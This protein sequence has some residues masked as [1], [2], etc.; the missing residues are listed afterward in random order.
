VRRLTALAILALAA[1]APSFAR[2]ASDPL[3]TGNYA[4]VKPRPAP[5]LRFGIDPGLAG[6]AGNVQLPSEPVNAAR[7][8]S[9]LKA[10]RPARRQLVLRLN[11]M[12]FSDGEAGIRRFQRETRSYAKDGFEVEL[13]VRYHPTPAQAGDLTAWRRYVR[14][15]VDAFGPNP[16]VVAMTITNEVNVSFSPNTS[17]GAFA[18]AQDALIE[19]IEAA[20]AEALR[21]GFGRLRFGFTYAYRFDP[22]HDVAF[23]ERLATR[24]GRSFR[25][26]LGFVGLD[27]YP[28]AVYPSLLPADDT[29]RHEFAQAAGVLRRC[30]LPRANIDAHVPIWVTETGVS[31]VTVG[32]GGQAAALLALAGAAR[33]YGRTF[34]VTDFRWFNLRDSIARADAPTPPPP[35]FAFDGLLRSD[36][37]RKAGFAAYRSLIARFGARESA[38]AARGCEKCHRRA[39]R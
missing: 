14:R 28:G 2:A 15:V 7:E 20:H 30:L 37:T 38:R 39:C 32:E 17:D 4:G 24:G 16:G 13:Q 33:D 36:Y 21:R 18:R 25:A 5:T 34:G 6:N 27:F 3:C 22:R 23:F 11:R 19:G 12:F 35:L 10:L 29:F 31:S 8:R 9:A 26:A 1:L